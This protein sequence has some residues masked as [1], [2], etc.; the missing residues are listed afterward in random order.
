MNH[1]ELTDRINEIHDETGFSF[2]VNGQKVENRFDHENRFQ[3]KE[4]DIEN[5][6]AYS[7]YSYI[8]S[9]IIFKAQSKEMTKK[10]Y[11]CLDRQWENIIQSQ[12]TDIFDNSKVIK[13]N[14][15]RLLKSFLMSDDDVTME[16]MLA[17]FSPLCVLKDISLQPKKAKKIMR[18]FNRKKEIIF[19]QVILFLRALYHSFLGRKD[20]IA[21]RIHPDYENLSNGIFSYDE[22]EILVPSWQ[23]AFCMDGYKKVV[24]ETLSQLS[25]N[26][27]MKDVCNISL[28]YLVK[29]IIVTH[30]I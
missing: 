19:N 6:L 3:Y 11:D 7:L 18:T 4:A 29:D 16:M 22:T 15:M 27:P 30:G 26:F 10:G 13:D 17:K 8:A 9:A 2:F 12:K 23:N 5:Q 24:T 28:I 21:D 1:S 20:I 25:D 14:A